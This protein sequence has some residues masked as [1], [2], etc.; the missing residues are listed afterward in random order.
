MLEALGASDSELVILLGRALY[1]VGLDIST[2]EIGCDAV[3]P[4]RVQHFIRWRRDGEGTEDNILG[5]KIFTAML[6][7]DAAVLRLDAR[8]GRLAS[9]AR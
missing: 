7:E 3:D 8:S 5:G 2:I 1:A 9:R 6:E 4:E